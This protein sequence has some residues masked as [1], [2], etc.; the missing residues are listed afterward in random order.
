[1]LHTLHHLIFVVE[2]FFALYGKVHSSFQVGTSLDEK[3]GLP[4]L[5]LIL[6][7]TVSIDQDLSPARIYLYYMAS[8]DL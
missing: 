8:N 6:S 4:F 2:I 3:K 1:M 7:G 5:M